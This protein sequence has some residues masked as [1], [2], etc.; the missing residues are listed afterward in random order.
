M[1]VTLTV[2][3]VPGATPVTVTMPVTLM[4]ACA[5]TGAVAAADQPKSAPSAKLAT[6]TVKPS[7]VGVAVPKVGTSLASSAR[8]VLEAVPSAYPSRTVL[9][10]TV[11]LSP[12]PRPVTVIRPVALTIAEAGSGVAVADQTNAEPAAKLSICVVKP[13]SV[14][15]AALSS[16]TY[17]SPIG[18]VRETDSSAPT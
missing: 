1:V 8:P 3:S 2:A 5:P 4:S 6:W 18:I 9:T 16:G 7:A 13:S 17:A 11:L 15:T 10:A 12:G 14:R